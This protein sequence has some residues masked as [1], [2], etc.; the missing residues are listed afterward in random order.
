M[1]FDPLELITSD[2]NFTP[3]H[4][5]VSMDNSM[6]AKHDIIIEEGKNQN[7]S[8]RNTYE[9]TLATIHNQSVVDITINDRKMEFALEESSDMLASKR[10]C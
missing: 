5:N 3:G 6:K 1:E 8:K 7:E 2:A 9:S 10:P 4:S